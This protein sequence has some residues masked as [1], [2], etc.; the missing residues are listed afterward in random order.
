MKAGNATPN[1][2]IVITSAARDL[3]VTGS[4]MLCAVRQRRPNHEIVITSAARDLLSL[5]VTSNR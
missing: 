2:E 5:R 1:H 3:L 4:G